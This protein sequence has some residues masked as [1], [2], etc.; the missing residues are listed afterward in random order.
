[1]NTRLLKNAKILVAAALIAVSCNKEEVFEYAATPQAQCFQAYAEMPADAATKSTISENVCSWEVGDSILISDGTKT[2]KFIASAVDGSGKATFQLKAGEAQLSETAGTEYEAWYPCSI[3]PS[4]GKQS[5]GSVFEG[6]PMHAKSSSSDLHFK[7]LC[8]LLHLVVSLPTGADNVALK[9]VSIK[10]ND[11]KALCGDFTVRNDAMVAS[12]DGNASTIRNKVSKWVSESHDYWMPLP[13]ATYSD[14]DI[15]LASNRG[16][17]QV[18]RLKSGKSITVE[19]SKA[20]TVNL[21]ADDISYVDLSAGDK[22]A[23]CYICKP[24][25]T[26]KFQFKATKGNSV[27]YIEGIDHVGLIWKC[28][29]NASDLTDKI[30][31]SV[32]YK[33]GYVRF[34]TSNNQGNA[35][36]AAYDKSDNILW[37][38]HIW[39]CGTT[40]QDVSLGNGV[41]I[42]D[43][44]IGALNSSWDVNTSGSYSSHLS[45]GCY[46]QWGRKDPFVSRTNSATG[47]MAVDG[48]A[49]NIV[50]SAGTVAESI[51]HPT[52]FYAAGSAPWTSDSQATWAGE[53]K[54][55]YDP[56]PAGYRVPAKADFEAVWTADN[57]TEKKASRSETDLAILGYI[58]KNSQSDQIW[59]PTT[60]QIGTGG[61]LTAGTTI[62]ASDKVVTSAVQCYSRFWTREENHSF[63]DAV[64]AVVKSKTI[65]DETT[66]TIRIASSANCYGMTVRCVKESDST[67]QASSDP[68]VTPWKENGYEGKTFICN[69]KIQVGVDMEHGGCVF[70]LSQASNKLNVLNHYDDGRYVQQS[71]YGDADGSSWLATDWKYNPVQGGGYKNGYAAKVESSEVTASKIKCTTIP[72]HWATC[73]ALPECRMMEEIT[74]EGDI[75]HIRYTFTY[76]G[77]IA[78]A[79]RGQEMPAVFIIKE[80]NTLV[81]YD[82]DSPWSNGELTSEIPVDRLTTGVN[83][84]LTG[85]QWSEK[86][87]AYVNSEGW[88]VGV[89]TPVSTKAAYYRFG[90]DNTDNSCSY[91]APVESFALIPGMRRTYD[92]YLTIGSTEEIRERFGE[93]QYK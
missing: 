18:F 7:N 22:T 74:L 11:G 81:Y 29:N 71:Y 30:V 24:S 10:S 48:T 56:C 32:S 16:C 62:L 1:M 2:S 77:T 61:A 28:Q 35:L 83:C 8:G 65:A 53:S 4:G 57:L 3:A 14:I 50:S 46:F 20:Y 49:R 31:T 90:S 34:E 43:R 55:I 40:P 37:S 45:S 92:V 42:L 5:M 73:Q 79:T 12:G 58:F 23:N 47:Q 51:K 82:G 21:L 87:G 93:I 80:L 15:V 66:K 78:H 85:S 70:H 13:A 64:S 17:S 6:N 68:G 41:T 25:A 33:N 38:W 36:I 59:F 72:V 91:I 27:D 84:N 86:W 60:G 19:R 26:G 54:T 63:V 44:N 75:A 39:S 9:E 76:N 89:Y 88:G 52:D 67:P 69:G